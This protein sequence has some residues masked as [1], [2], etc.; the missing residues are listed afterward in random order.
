MCVFNV[1]LDGQNRC[2]DLN[3]ILDENTFQSF[4][5]DAVS[6]GFI[7]G[8]YLDNFMALNHDYSIRQNAGD[9]EISEVKLQE[10]KFSLTYRNKVPYNLPTRF[11]YWSTRNIQGNAV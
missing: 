1:D 7:S 5:S 2:T 4:T 9:I 6:P 11:V 3:W 10:G 8:L